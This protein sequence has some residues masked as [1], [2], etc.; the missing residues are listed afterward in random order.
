MPY[1]WCR[2]YSPSWSRSAPRRNKKLQSPR[3]LIS[4]YFY[5]CIDM[6]RHYDHY[7]TRKTSKSCHWMLYK[8]RED[9]SRQF[10]LADNNTSTT[11]Q[12]IRFTLIQLRSSFRFCI[13]KS[14]LYFLAVIL[15]LATE[16]ALGSPTAEAEFGELEERGRGGDRGGDRDWD[17][18]H[19][20]D[21]DRNPCEVKR[22]Y[23]YYKYP[24]GSSPTT[25][26]SQVGAI[27]T[28]SCKYQSVLP[29]RRCFHLLIF[30]QGMVTLV[31]GTSL[32]RDGSRIPTSHVGAV[33]NS[34]LPA[35]LFVED[36]C[37]DTHFSWNKQA[38]YLVV[39]VWMA[40]Q[41]LMSVQPGWVRLRF[42]N[43]ISNLSK[44]R[45]WILCIALSNLIFSN[46]I[47]VSYQKNPEKA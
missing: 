35:L 40:L 43:H 36:D 47:I 26:M 16:L 12:I 45:R 11:L 31:F 46:I 5:F 20:W 24:C 7:K 21:H 19:G 3:Y 30:A 37:T 14:P 39:Y 41:L 29:P 4:S 2:N 44:K 1:P 10:Y 27:F 6:P 38:M 23:P 28:P 9:S 17:D 32:P 34:S 25:G 18:R 22:S 13:M 8:A 33:S 42:L 15:P